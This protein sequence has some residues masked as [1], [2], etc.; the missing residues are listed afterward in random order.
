MGD[1]L[2]AGIEGLGQISDILS[3]IEDF[4]ARH[5][6]PAAAVFHLQLAC[7]EMLTNI[8]S[9][10]F[11]DARPRDIHVSISLRQDMIE[12]EIIDNGIPFNP[13]AQ[14]EPDLTLPLE[15]RKIGGL[16]IHIIRTVM[17]RLNYHRSDG[18]NHLKMVLQ[19]SANPASKGDN[20]W[21]THS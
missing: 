6:L 9:Y 15:E 10:G 20:S 4:A 12:V 19:L 17:N 5:R 8:I 2:Q 11:P 13:L 1:H 18:R 14:P 16:G 3:R 21:P 7:D